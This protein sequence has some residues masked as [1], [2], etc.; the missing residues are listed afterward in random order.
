LPPAS[1]W[2]LVINSIGLLGIILLSIPLLYA[3]KYARA[4]AKHKEPIPRSGSGRDRVPA[5]ER[6]S[7]AYND[8]EMDIIHA[9]L[10]QKLESVGV[11][12]TRWK[13]ASL[14]TG[15][16]LTILSYVIGVI[17]AMAV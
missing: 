2:D 13:S 11:A 17:K 4:L 14:I 7:A 5:P 3:N 9:A 10:E 8:P 6:A 16:I 1:I 12:W 15:T